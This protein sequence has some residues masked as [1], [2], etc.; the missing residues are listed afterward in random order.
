MLYYERILD[1]LNDLFFKLINELNY[2]IFKKN[3]FDE[4][5]FFIRNK[6]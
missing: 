4:K 1:I 5:K 2:K 6:G 3:F